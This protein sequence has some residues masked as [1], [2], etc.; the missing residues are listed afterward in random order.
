MEHFKAAQAAAKTKRHDDNWAQTY[1]ARAIWPA[2]P[3]KD[4][5][6]IH[7]I[8]HALALS[9]RWTGH[10]RRHYSVA[11]HSVLVSHLVP[12]RHALAALLHD[13]SEA[14]VSDI[15]RPV[16]PEIKGYDDVEERLL[17][18][19]LRRYGLGGQLPKSVKYADNIMLFTEHRDLLR[20]APRPWKY[21]P[22]GPLLTR[23]IRPWP[24]WWAEFRFLWRFGKLTGTLQET[25]TQYA[26][27][28][29]ADVWHFD[30]PTFRAVARGIAKW[31]RGDWDD[32]E[33]KLAMMAN[34]RI[35][36][37]VH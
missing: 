25:M 11:Q 26:K 32:A 22:L 10:V 14:Y 13:A 2:H 6:N 9:C 7:D 17:R 23:R 19:I 3:R 8:A 27:H 15:A 35:G 4:E 37:A 5:V 33:I 18:T 34:L 28:K 21:K 36:R 1:T 30:L 29:A 20:A 24:I 31:W 12:L 16:K